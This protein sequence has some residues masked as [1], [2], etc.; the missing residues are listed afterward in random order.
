MVHNCLLR[1]CQLHVVLACDIFPG[2]HAFYPP[3]VL[4]VQT[5]LT[6][7]LSQH[8]YM[9]FNFLETKKKKKKTSLKPSL[10]A[11]IKICSQPA[12]T[13]YF[14]PAMQNVYLQKGKS[15]A[16]SATSLKCGGVAE[17]KLLEVVTWH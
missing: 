8:L 17:E 5:E 16:I 2:H 12:C 14:C 1:L 9:A 7:L 11:T 4:R 6:C 10:S 13:A 3:I 15:K